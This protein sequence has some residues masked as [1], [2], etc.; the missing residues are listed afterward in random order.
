MKDKR[1]RGTKSRG[2]KRK[3]QRSK[4]HG[5]HT[6]KNIKIICSINVINIQIKHMVV[7]LDKK[8]T[9]M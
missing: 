6:S 5:R 1:K 7:R 4:L 9:T 2:E 8:E 3:Q